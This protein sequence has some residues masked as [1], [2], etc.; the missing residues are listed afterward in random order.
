MKK[1]KIIILVVLAIVII[2]AGILIATR[3]NNNGELSNTVN[4][5]MAN[6]S[7]PEEEPEEPKDES[8]ETSLSVNSSEVKQLYDYILKVNENQEELTYRSETVTLEDLNDQ[9]KIMTVFKNLSEDDADNTKQVTDE[10]GQ[11]TKHVYYSKETVD[12]KAKSIFGDDV[13]IKHQSSETLLA[14]AIDYKDGQYDCY[15]YQ[16]GGDYP[17]SMS[18]S[19]IESAEQ[20]DNEIYI[21][22]KYVHI[23]STDDESSTYDIYDSSDKTQKIAEGVKYY[24]LSYN[25]DLDSIDDREKAAEL[26]MK[27]AEEVTNNKIKTFKHTFK[28]G[29]DGNYYWYS[30]EPVEE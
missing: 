28:K 17:W 8:L 22:D 4:E 29:S 24:K 19:K 25:E 13:T 11:T 18:C 2:I 26:T 15:E 7:E 6:T 16:G 21:Y 27:N 23:T 12:K 10:Y 3:N 14:H 20:K 9:L 30:T 1:V 5:T